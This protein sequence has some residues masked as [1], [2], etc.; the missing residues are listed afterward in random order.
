V[1]RCETGGD[2]MVDEVSS[3]APSQ[4]PD[5]EVVE[6]SDQQKTVWNNSESDTMIHSVAG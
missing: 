2:D 5:N 6:K 3:A 1:L 4:V